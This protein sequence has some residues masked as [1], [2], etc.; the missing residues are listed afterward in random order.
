MSLDSIKQSNSSHKTLNSLLREKN[1]I[2]RRAYVAT[3]NICNQN[4]AIQNIA[5]ITTF[6]VEPP[7][8]LLTASSIIR[9]KLLFVN[10]WNKMCLENIAS[11]DIVK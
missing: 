3:K 5:P 6:T 7:G 2:L 11:I 9:I 10:K 1:I 8:R 4:S